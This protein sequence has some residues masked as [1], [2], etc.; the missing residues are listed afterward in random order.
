MLLVTTLFLLI[1]LC[2]C[3]TWAILRAA[4]STPS[5]RLNWGNPCRQPFAANGRALLPTPY[6]IGQRLKRNM[7]TAL[8]RI[9]ALCLS[10]LLTIGNC[11]NLLPPNITSLRASHYYAQ[12]TATLPQAISVMWSGLMKRIG[13]SKRLPACIVMPK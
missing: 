12:Q 6:S 1:A 13:C 9:S 7:G 8:S 3:L 5:P 11:R 4:S 2:G 10:A